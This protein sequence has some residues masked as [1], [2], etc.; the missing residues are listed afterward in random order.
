M[1]LG[2]SC[3]PKG[4]QGQISGAACLGLGR[5]CGCGGTEGISSNISEL[6]GSK[7][8]WEVASAPSLVLFCTEYQQLK[9]WHPCPG[10]GVG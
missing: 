2:C 5:K 8:G 1:T 10:G 6:G 9:E 4:K 7:L 3:S